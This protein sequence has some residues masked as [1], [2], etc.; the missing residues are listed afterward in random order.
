MDLIIYH[1]NCPDGFCAA[2]IAHKRYPEAVLMPRDHGLEP[3]YEEVAGKDVLV[4]DFSWGT[5]EQNLELARRAKSF[6]ILDHH[7]TAQ[8]VL[9][10]LDFATFDMN[11]SGAGLTWDYIFGKNSEFAELSTSPMG[12]PRPW[13]VDYVED[14]DLWRK[15]L[16]NTDEVNAY[17]MTLP[18]DLVSWEVLVAM[19]TYEEAAFKG[20]GALAHIEHYVREALPHGQKGVLAGYPALIVNALYMN[21]SEVAGELAKLCDGIGIGYFER[22]DGIMQFSLRSRNDVDVSAI[23]KLL[24][25]GG[26]KNAA[27]FQ[28]PVRLGR[29]FVDLVLRR[30]ALPP[31]TPDVFWQ[32]FD[33]NAIR[34]IA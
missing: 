26:H 14:R 18:Y 12:K 19:K 27:G 16:P 4:L 6:R 13:Y 7:K 9:E 33:V 24:G 34:K 32:I 25:G 1:N 20:R 11:R 5:R 15:V 31:F 28:L 29:L 2:V 21:I 30:I 23:A 8:A 17:I 10:G 3:P 22:G